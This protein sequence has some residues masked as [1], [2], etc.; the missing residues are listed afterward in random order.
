ML[1]ERESRG[2]VARAIEFARG[3]MRATRVQNRGTGA[4]REFSQSIYRFGHAGRMSAASF[5][6]GLHI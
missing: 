6:N 3:R 5:R 4:L 2:L 1:L